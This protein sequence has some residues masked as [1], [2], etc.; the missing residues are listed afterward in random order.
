MTRRLIA[1]LRFL[2]E[3]WYEST[4]WLEEN[5]LAVPLFWLLFL[6]FMALGLWQMTDLGNL[7]R[8]P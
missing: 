8:R 6:T 7:S 5:G 4:G 2:R 3:A 1:A